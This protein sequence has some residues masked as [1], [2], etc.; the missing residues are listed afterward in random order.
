V[1]LDFQGWD[2]SLLMSVRSYHSPIAVWTAWVFASLAWKGV[3]AWIMALIFWIRGHR[4]LASQFVLA[5]GTGTLAIIGLKGAVLRPRPDLFAARELNIPMPELLPTQHSF[6]SGHTLL[7]A[8]I[9]MVLV[10]RYRDWRAGCAVAFVFLVGWARVYQGMHWPSDIVGSVILGVVAGI[11]AVKVS[12]LPIVRSRTQD[13]LAEPKPP[14]VSVES[15][16][17]KETAGVR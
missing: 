9:M 2:L 8:A 3:T 13:C 12:E 4:R 14:A 16:R 11:A 1:Q 7:A 10:S 5:L 15:G 6:P 17:P